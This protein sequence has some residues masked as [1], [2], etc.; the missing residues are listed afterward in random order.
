MKHF[1]QHLNEGEKRDQPP[2]QVDLRDAGV[3]IVLLNR[4]KI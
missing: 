3:E 2:D 1:E 4:K